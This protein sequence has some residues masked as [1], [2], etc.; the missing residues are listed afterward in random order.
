MRTWKENNPLRYKYNKLRDNA[1]R[2][3][4][5]FT[6]SF[7]Y[8]KNFI[9]ENWEYMSKSGRTKRSL[10]I[11]RKEVHLG[12]VPGNLQI[13]TCSENCKKRHEEYNDQNLPF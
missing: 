3:G 9:E 4:K 8:F 5:Q 2:R 7:D 1:R 13:L 6:I 10:H 12:Y 11:D